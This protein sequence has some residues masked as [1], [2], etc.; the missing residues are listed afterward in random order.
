MSTLGHLGG[1]P[2]FSQKNL[3]SLPSRFIFY[4][5]KMDD[6]LP[7]FRANIIPSYKFDSS[8]ALTSYTIKHI[9]L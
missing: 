7:D 8:C 4:I 6:C 3:P 5:P 1:A 2:A 9:Y